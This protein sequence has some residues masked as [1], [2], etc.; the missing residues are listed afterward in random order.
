[1]VYDIIGD[2]IGD[3]HGIMGVIGDNRSHHKGEQ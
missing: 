2:K 3:Y 1:M